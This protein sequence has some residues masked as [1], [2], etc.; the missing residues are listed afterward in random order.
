MVMARQQLERLLRQVMERSMALGLLTN[1]H[2][3]RLET[4]E[5][6]FNSSLLTN[7]VA[8]IVF[9]QTVSDTFRWH[10]P[11]QCKETMLR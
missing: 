6:C 8:S 5:I 10:I 9:Y 7:T 3:L 4:T 1:R 2:C 11:D